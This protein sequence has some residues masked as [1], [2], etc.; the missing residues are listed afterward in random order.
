MNTLSTTRFRAK[1][2]VTNTWMENIK[3]FLKKY[4]THGEIIHI[5][6]SKKTHFFLIF[7]LLSIGHS[8][9]AIKSNSG[10]IF[11]DSNADG[12][13]EAVINN[14]GL[15]IGSTHSSSSNLHVSGNALISELTIGSTGAN[16]SSSSNLN[17]NGTLGHSIE[18]ISSSTNVTLSGNHSMVLVNPSANIYITLPDANAITGR[19]L[20]IKNTS[21][22]YWVQLQSNSPV[23]YGSSLMLL[24]TSQTPSVSLFASGNHWRITSGTGG[25]VNSPVFSDNLLVWLSADDLDGD[26]VQ[27]GSSEDYIDGSGNIS[28]CIGKLNGQYNATQAD[29]TKRPVFVANSVGGLPGIKFNPDISSQIFSFGNIPMNIRKTVFVVA[30]AYQY[31]DTGTGSS[32]K[33]LSYSNASISFRTS[34]TIRVSWGQSNGGVNF[35]VGAIPLNQGVIVSVTHDNISL[36]AHVYMNGAASAG[37]PGTINVATA[38]P[39]RAIGDTDL[40][41]EVNEV[42]IY[43]D[44]LSTHDREKVE[45]Y[46]SQKWNIT[47]NR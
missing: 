28:D 40:D 15:S 11:F 23:E 33:L 44:V 42:I 6:Q 29:S 2:N 13:A 17:L 46:L 39:I 25:I 20:S 16:T 43:N 38:S 24:K 18:T 7:L 27:E 3:I 47:L 45:D 32:G 37:N 26:G 34:S 30:K 1:S 31:R 4:S 14:S 22:T 35:N 12:T 41:G 9:T 10:N 5:D 19:S 8:F 36:D 21:D